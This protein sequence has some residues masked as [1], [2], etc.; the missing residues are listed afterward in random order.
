MSSLA[1]HL[2]CK[3]IISKVCNCCHYIVF[4]VRG[5][6]Y[7]RMKLCLRRA[8]ASAPAQ[9]TAPRTKLARINRKTA[10]VW[11]PKPTAVTGRI[12]A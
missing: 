1:A 12:G 2:S 7:S 4:L 5:G 6:G 11:V 10:G 8:K 9:K 3:D